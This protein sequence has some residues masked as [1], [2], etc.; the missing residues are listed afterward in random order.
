MVSQLPSQLR[1]VARAIGLEPQRS[2]QQHVVKTDDMLQHSPGIPGIARRPTMPFSVRRAHRIAE[3]PAHR[4]M[5]FAQLI[6]HRNQPGSC[7]VSSTGQHSSPRWL[8]TSICKSSRWR[9]GSTLASRRL[10]TTRP[11]P[12]IVSPA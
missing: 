10:A 2:Q 6:R 4:E 9:G 7:R 5:S 12:T 11:R 3:P 1:I 8:V